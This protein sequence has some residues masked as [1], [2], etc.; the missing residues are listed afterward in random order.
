MKL[1]FKHILLLY[2][3]TGAF[4]SNGQQFGNEWINYSQSYYSFKVVNDGVHRIDHATLVAA[5]IPVGSFQ[6]DNIQ[7]FGKEREIPLLINDNGDNTIDAGDYIVFYAERNDGWLDSTLYLDAQTIGNPAYSLYNDTIQYFFTWNNGSSNLRYVVETDID[8]SNYSNVEDYVLYTYEHNFNN[9][10]QEGIRSS[11]YS[12]SFYMPGEGWGTG[13]INGVP[14]NGY[15]LATASPTPQPY[16]GPGAPDAFFTGL[17]SSGSNTTHHLRWEIG[18]SNFPLLDT[19]FSSYK[20]IKANKSFD[21]ALLTNGNTNVNWRII[22][23]QGSP[24]DFQAVNYF[25][26]S[27]PRTTNFQSATQLNFNI[28]N[29]P[30][31]KIRIDATNVG[32]SNPL[33]FIHGDIPRYIPFESYSGGHSALIPNSGNGVNQ[34]AI[35]IDSS[36]IIP[37]NSLSPVNGTGQFNDFSNYPGG[38]EAALLFVY[39]PKLYTSTL[40]YRDHRESNA[41]GNH[42]VVL[43]NVNELYQQFG[44]GIEKH[45]NGIRRFSHYIY[46]N[47]SIKPIGLFLVGKGIREAE[48]NSTLSDGPGARKNI[49]RFHTSLVPSFGQPSSDVCITANLIGG[50]TWTPLIPTGRI[51]A[52]TDAELDGYLQKVIAYDTKQ[53]P[54]D[55]YDTPSKDW[56][57]QVLHFVG[58]TDANQQT[59]FRNFM[60]NYKN[61]IEDSLFG[62]NVHS[63]YK[64]NSNPLGPTA[65]NAITERISNGVS[66]MTYFGH[67]SSTT[68]GFEINLDE[69]GNW[70][71]TGK[72]PIMLVN[73]CYNGNIFQL[74]TSKSE[75]FVQIPNLGAIAY[76][77]S[78]SVGFDS[79]LNTYS[80]RLYDHFSR[81]MYG[82]NIANQ[83]RATINTLY[84]PSDTMLETTCLQ[85]VLN[86]DPMLKLNSHQNPEIELLAENVSF[87]PNNLNLTVDSIEMHIILTNLGR[88]VTSPFNLEVTRNFPGTSVDSVYNFQISNLHYKDT[89][90]FKM[91]LQPNISVGINTFNIRVDLPSQITE[92]Y[93]ETGNNQLVKTLYIDIDGIIPVVPFNFAVVPDDSVTVRASTVNPI[94]GFNTYRFEIDTTDLFNSPMHRYANVS[95]L[96]GVKEVHPSQWLSA[97]SGMSAPLVCTDSTVYFWRVA[98]DSSVYDWRERSFQYIVGKTGW[99]QDHFF[100]FKNNSFFGIDYNRPDRQRDFGLFSRLITCDVYS[101]SAVPDIYYN[102]WYI[103]GNQQDYGI[104]NSTPKLHVAVVDPITLEAWATRY[105]PTGANLDNNFGNNNDNLARPWKYFT[106]HQDDPVRL[107]AFQNMVN[108]EIPDGHYI[109]IYSPLTTR[110][111]LWN[112]LD[113]TDMYNTFAALGSDSI[114]GDR[115]NT[116][117]AFFC[118]KGDP[119]SVVELFAPSIPGEVHLTATA[120][121]SEEGQEISPLIGPSASW[122]NVYWK[123]DPMEVSSMDSTV[124]SISTYNGA[125]VFQNRID[126]TFTL[127][128][129]IIDLNNIV[130]AAQF[131]YISLRAHYADNVTNTPAQV[132]RWHVLFQPL[133]EAAIDGSNQYLWSGTDTLQ[134]GQNVDFAIDIRNIYNLDM[135]S[136]L[137]SYWIEDENQIK[138]PIPYARQDSLR[139]PDVLRDTITF[140]TAG[141]GGINSL[142]VEVNPYVNGSLYIKDQPEQEHFNNLLQIPFYVNADDKNPILDVTFNG[143][144]IINGDIIDPNSEVLITLKDDNEFLIMDNVSD[145][146]LFGIYLTDP[147]GNVK[148]IP[149]TDG[150]GN[151]VMQWIPAEPQQKRFKIIWPSAFEMDGK[152]TLYVQ[153]SDR[154]GNLSGD[155]EY[156]VTFEVIHE[157]TI[158]NMMNYPNP[159]STST[160]FVF[161]LTGSETPD[162]IL[163]QIMTVTG[164]IVKEINEAELGPIQI[165]RNIT[166]FAWDGTDEFGDPLANGV[167]LYRVKAR[168]NGENIK[169]RD[170]GADS[171][172]T[173][174]FGKMYLM[175]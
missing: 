140:S 115:V 168:I 86:G 113:S 80:R 22:N 142:W 65:L 1:T 25:S 149:F 138:H 128:D 18:A 3:F 141:L 100:Q 117:F 157:S 111:D 75:Q 167:Y 114:N 99:G 39:H 2:L 82:E 28:I 169:H 130:D 60:D 47:S 104:L 116:P 36:L 145:T 61:I 31:G 27:Y 50:N 67:S 38:I 144:H 33:L 14:S 124:L 64:S 109:L 78:V 143:N 49:N 34:T 174:D 159:F 56:Q 57:K 94:A 59:T 73:S 66:L 112:S 151:T 127:N 23:D 7:I 16:T 85:M 164:R 163:I 165:G 121:G 129:S 175:R 92:Q 62:G 95:G 126:T 13:S 148:R 30:Q 93:D 119:A 68:S 89:F 79:P 20:Q 118:K 40:A 32:A 90:Q 162:D 91:P 8:F 46:Y 134:E 6:S 156:R 70:N 105:V 9:G 48:Y 107:D 155:I 84:N 166:E 122:G 41:G 52:R 161:T 4:F 172:F 132:D 106:F 35:Y 17:S 87:T 123:Q 158:T 74:S 108:N 147:T 101:S 152:Y 45:I 97:S 125:G 58:G 19:V 154:S 5:G 83:M 153:G 44:G 160:R 102:A 10:Y 137:V 135:D 55:V 77:A 11:K 96:G 29:N 133:P 131:P 136:L 69:P 98:V 103:D 26:I 53:D 170:S 37:V 76:I 24:T 72:Y 42:N 63:T 43:A 171:H 12:S 51:S 15:V 120:Y 139:V 173:K 21:P 88:S 150:N 146:S 110:Y 54:L 81:S 71:N